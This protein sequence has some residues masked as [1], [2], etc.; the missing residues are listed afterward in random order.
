MNII[1]YII[2]FIIGMVFVS[3]FQKIKFSA[4]GSCVG[5]LFMCFS[6]CGILINGTELI[7]KRAALKIIPEWNIQKKELIKIN[8]EIIALRKEEKIKIFPIEKIE[9]KTYSELDIGTRKVIAKDVPYEYT[10]YYKNNNKHEKLTVN[11]TEN[12]I[13]ITDKEQKEKTIIGNTSLFSF[14]II[15]TEKSVSGVTRI[16][17]DI[18][19]KEK[20]V[21]KIIFVNELKDIE[22][23]KIP[24][25]I[26]IERK[27]ISNELK[28][29]IKKIYTWITQEKLKKSC[30]YPK[31]ITWWNEFLK[32]LYIDE[33]MDFSLSAN[34]FATKKLIFKQYP[35]GIEYYGTKNEIIYLPKQWE[36]R[37]DIPTFI[38]IIKK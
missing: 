11:T 6:F 10:F 18:E 14:D 30:D 7:D 25:L 37:K 9:V 17:P 1:V 20:L 29:R 33:G 27:E 34:L 24:S 3:Y 13:V 38:K 32:T 8:N 2:V 36:A 5:I 16:T 12:Q 15:K 19:I 26:I 28:E 31:Y 4:V 21:N 22:K 35:L 23:N